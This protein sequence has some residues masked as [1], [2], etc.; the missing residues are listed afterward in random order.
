MT[1]RQSAAQE[2]PSE[3]S[4]NGLPFDLKVLLL[5]G[6]ADR[7]TLLSLILSSRAYHAVYAEYSSSVVQSVCLTEV[8]PMR[9]DARAAAVAESTLLRVPGGPSPADVERFLTSYAS[10]RCSLA[11]MADRKAIEASIA[12][13][14]RYVDRLARY[15]LRS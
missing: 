7:E 13:N 5:K 14:H 8:E 10:G 4:L 1:I 12:V 3:A 15:C 9:L 2:R 11:G 6:V